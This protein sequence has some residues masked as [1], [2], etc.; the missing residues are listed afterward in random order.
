LQKA[1]KRLAYSAI[2]ALKYFSFSFP[3]VKHERQVCPPVPDLSQAFLIPEKQI[4]HFLLKQT[5]PPTTDLDLFT[6]LP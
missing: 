2:P 5:K 1:P 4:P 6:D 3:T